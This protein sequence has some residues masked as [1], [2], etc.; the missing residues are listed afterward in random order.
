MA[1]STNFQHHRLWA[2]PLLHLHIS[3]RRKKRGTCRTSRPSHTISMCAHLF[4]SRHKKIAN[5]NWQ[6]KKKCFTNTAETKLN[7]STSLSCQSL[8]CSASWWSSGFHCSRGINEHPC[9]QS[10]C[11]ITHYP[12][13]PPVDTAA[14]VAQNLSIFSPWLW[15]FC[16]IYLK[17]YAKG[18][19]GNAKAFEDKLYT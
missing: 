6:R 2:A 10:C 9:L 8:L 4:L 17:Q 15:H 11:K 16:V 1:Q 13:W 7:E 12:Y 19:V 14:M 5:R 3:A 18:E